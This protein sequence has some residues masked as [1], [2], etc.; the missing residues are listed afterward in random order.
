MNYSS[1]LFASGCTLLL[2]KPPF[3]LNIRTK[4][5]HKNMMMYKRTMR[6]AA[7]STTIISLLSSQSCDAFLSSSGRRTSAVTSSNNLNLPATFVADKSRKHTSCRAN[8]TPLFMS[9]PT[10]VS[11]S[12]HELAAAAQTTPQLMRALWQLAADASKNMQKGVSYLSIIIYIL[13]V[14]LCIQL[15]HQYQFHYKTIKSFHVNNHY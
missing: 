10:Q 12:I 9:A 15:S 7:I 11:D 5:N 2:D 3:Q 14:N 1:L 8:N 13:C 6:A 4:A